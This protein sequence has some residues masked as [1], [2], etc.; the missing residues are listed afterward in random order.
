MLSG[1]VIAGYQ[2]EVY[3]TS[4]YSGDDSVRA[5]VTD[6]DSDLTVGVYAY[7]DRI[8]VYMLTSDGSIVELTRVHTRENNKVTVNRDAEGKYL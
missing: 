4:E 7:K 1:G 2:Q 3:N 6:T 8:I 5:S